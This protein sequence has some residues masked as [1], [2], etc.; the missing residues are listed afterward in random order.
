VNNVVDETLGFDLHEVPMGKK[1][2]K[3]Y[4]GS[5]CKAL[6]LKLKEDSTVTG[7]EVKAFTNS[8]PLFCKWLLSQYDELQFYTTSSMDPE[9][10]MVF[11]Y[12]PEG[13]VN[14]TFVY[15]TMGMRSEKC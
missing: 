4:L 9:G 10:S 12:Y 1:D 2:L 13:A 15:I 6:R 8:A 11:S 5:Y 7:P 14:P 3:E